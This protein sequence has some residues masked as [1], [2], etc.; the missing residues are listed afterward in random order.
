MRHLI[1]SFAASVILLAAT[2]T[3]LAQCYPNPTGETAVGLKNASS[4]FLTFYIDGVNKGG[5][6]AGDR[7]VDFMVTPGEH[8]FRAEA[9][10]N[11][12]VVSAN[13]IATVPSGHVC[14]W[15]VTN[16]Q[17]AATYTAGKNVAFKLADWLELERAYVTI[18]VPN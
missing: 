17:K 16:P 9:V 3:A 5:V 14:A 7:S 13:R 15:N 1:I 10:I 4:H 18:A 8:K 12:E 6:P 11:G 2:A